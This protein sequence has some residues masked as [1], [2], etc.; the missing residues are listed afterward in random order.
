ME[1]RAV[2]TVSDVAVII[3]HK[4]TVPDWVEAVGTV[5]AAQTSQVASQ[6]MGNHPRNSRSG[7]RPRGSPAKFLQ[8][9]TIPSRAPR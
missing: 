4:T 7:R 1:T 5:R 3:V 9:L 8:Q 2:E 6:M